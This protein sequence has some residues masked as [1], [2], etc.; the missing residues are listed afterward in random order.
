MANDFEWV[1]IERGFQAPIAAVWAMWTDPARFASWYGP[2]GAQVEVKTMDVTVG[3]ARHF[4]MS[5]KMPDRTMT[6][7]FVGKYT[8]VNEPHRLVYTESMADEQGNV[9]S[10]QS[11]GMPEGHPEVTEVIVELAE[12]GEGTAMIMTHVGVP[13]DSGGAGGWAQAMDKLA[14]LLGD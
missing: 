3:G 7:W 9:V 1:R 14:A 10:P 2:N 4:S 13:A 5:M 8:E 11:M 6:M 12:S